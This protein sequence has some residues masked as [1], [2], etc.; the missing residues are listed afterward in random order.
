[1]L[2]TLISILT[3]CEIR[4]FDVTSNLG[5]GLKGLADEGSKDLART[6]N[7]RSD[8]VQLFGRSSEPRARI[9]IKI[10]GNTSYRPP[11]AF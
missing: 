10:A 2:K 9:W 11:G 4:V 7:V 5:K 3:P 6:L 8:F 1:M